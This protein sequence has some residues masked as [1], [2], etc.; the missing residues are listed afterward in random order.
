MLPYDQQP[1]LLHSS[2]NGENGDTPWD[3]NFDRVF[4][5][6]IPLNEHASHAGLFIEYI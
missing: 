5:E 2:G 4:I 3:D 1:E 6:Q